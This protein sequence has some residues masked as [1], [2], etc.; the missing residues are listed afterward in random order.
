[1]YLSKFRT[2]IGSMFSTGV[3]V[4]SWSEEM[5]VEERKGGEGG[6]LDENFLWRENVWARNWGW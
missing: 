2:A 1:M 6:A 4:R 5:V 3:K